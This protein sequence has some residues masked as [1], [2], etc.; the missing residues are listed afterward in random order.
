MNELKLIGPLRQLLTMEALPLKGSL[1]DSQLQIVEQAGILISEGKILATGPFERLKNDYSKAELYELKGDHVCL[2]GF[3]DAHTHIC[4]GGNRANDYALR[5]SGK[6]YLEIAKS[7]GGIWDTVTQT[8]KAGK[9]ELI[10]KTTKLANRH[11]K[12][13]VTTLEVKSG[14]G[15]SVD[16]EIKMLEVIKE[17]NNTIPSDLIATCLAAHM[18]PKDYVGT[19]QEYLEELSTCL[20]PKIKEESLANRIDA[21]IEE[22]AFTAEDIAPYFSSAK[23]LGF[24]ITV[25]ADQFTTGGSKVAVDFGAISADHLEASTNEE[26]KL[27]AQSN[28]I[29][30]A[31]PGAS[32]GLG[33]GFTPARKLLDAGATL[34][35]A[36]DHNPGSAPMGDLLTQAAI[37][38]AFEKL[39]N[40]EVLAGITIRA[41]AA[42]NLKDRG[43]L[44]KGMLADFSLFHTN[45]YQEILY[46]QGNLKPCMVW[47]EGNLVF[48]KHKT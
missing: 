6:T 24:D 33:C 40:A 39:S 21:F 12:T 20:L 31:L 7:G 8:R 38:G 2:P 19:K 36:S 17:A 10:K 46:N 11:L 26:I 48:N 25:H 29:A 16:E 3:I 37:L 41:A 23:K 13:G 47:K 32:L 14:Y 4:F 45:N 30:T 15:L 18:F 1:S 44:A 28:T 22:S 35:I 27:L 9:A 42:L 34:A 5:N 43:K